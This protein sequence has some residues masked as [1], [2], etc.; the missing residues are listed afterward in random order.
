MRVYLDNVIASALVRDDLASPEER[1]ALK[2]I[3]EHRN[4]GKLKI[5]TS[6]ESWREKERTRNAQAHEELRS[7]RDNIE[8][9]SI[10]L[11]ETKT[12]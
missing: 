6:R 7:S 8:R 11:P 4:F 5:V 12:Q 3:Q 1:Q 2:L 10:L 9:L